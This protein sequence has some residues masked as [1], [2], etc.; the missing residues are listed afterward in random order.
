MKNDYRRYDA[1]FKR[2]AVDHLIRSGKT[3]R[4]AAQGRRRIYVYPAPMARAKTGDR[5]SRSPER[6]ADSRGETAEKGKRS[7]G[8]GEPNLKKVRGHLFKNIGDKYAFIKAHSSEFSIE[9]TARILKVSRSG[10]Y[11]WLHRPKSSREEANEELAKEIEEIFIGSKGTYGSPRIVATLDERGRQ[12]KRKRVMKIMRKLGISAKNRKK[13]RAVT[14]DS[15]HDYPISPNSRPEFFRSRTE[16]AMVFGHNI[17]SYRGGFRLCMH[18]NRHMESR[19]YR[20]V[21]SG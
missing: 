9:K 6:F 7:I 1:E 17:C 2:N 13:R 15:R 8:G 11:D 14:T 18:R 10:Y 21:N 4:D 20:L 19:N 3:L 12:A 16:S 5:R